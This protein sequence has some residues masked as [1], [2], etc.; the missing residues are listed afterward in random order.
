MDGEKGD[1]PREGAAVA[2][3]C[4]GT[5]SGGPAGMARR[6]HADW[7]AGASPPQDLARSPQLPGRP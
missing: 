1:V 2:S 6:G 4:F 3:R 5:R 7:G